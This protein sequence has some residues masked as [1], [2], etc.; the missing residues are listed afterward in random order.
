DA[1]GIGDREDVLQVEAVEFLPRPRGRVELE[2]LARVPG[3]AVGGEVRRLRFPG[4]PRTG[5]SRVY[6]SEAPTRS[7]SML[8]RLL[9]A[10]DAQAPVAQ[11]SLTL[12]L[13]TLVLV[14]L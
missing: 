5:A 1:P 7:W 6:C 10:E 13:N 9:T 2:R 14:S 11:S 8:V 3:A 12:L 4:E